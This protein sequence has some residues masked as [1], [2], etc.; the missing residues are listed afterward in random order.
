MFF[1]LRGGQEHR[2]LEWEHQI[3]LNYGEEGEYLTYTAQSSKNFHAG[4]RQASLKPKVV[5]VF[6]NKEKERC[7]I[8]LYKKYA[9]LRPKSSKT[10]PFYIKPKLQFTDKWFDDCP[11]GHNTLSGMLKSMCVS[12]NLVNGNYV[13][14]SLKKTAAT[15]LRNCSDVQKRAITGNGSASLSVYEHVTDSDYATYS[16]MLYKTTETHTKE[17]QNSEEIQPSKKMKVQIDGEK[18]K[19]VLTFQ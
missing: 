1:A 19:V 4:L 7:F 13:N 12:A 9:Q 8:R 3:N 6:S 18:K 16:N 17:I 10:K 15:T 11:V 2:E 5:K 14:H